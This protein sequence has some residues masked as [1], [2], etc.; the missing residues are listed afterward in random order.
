MKKIILLAIFLPLI[1]SCGGKKGEKTNAGDTYRNSLQDSIKTAQS[2][3]DSCT[4]KIREVTSTIDS[5]IGN[6]TNVE[7]PREVEGY[8][9]LSNWQSRYPLQS[10]GIIARISKSEQFEL[11][12][13]LK[14]GTFDQ[15]EVKSEGKSAFS[16]VVPNDQALNYRRDGITTV[17]FSGDECNDVGKFIADNGLNDITLCYLESGRQKSSWHI[18]AEYVEMVSQTWSF[19][20]ANRELHSLELQNSMLHQKIDIIRRHLE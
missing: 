7:N 15:I 14:G 1:A 3:I 10:T 2:K 12:A 18:P 16:S 11:I 8:Y 20:S 17:M 13:V 6:F 19:A 5:Q 9:I 4:L